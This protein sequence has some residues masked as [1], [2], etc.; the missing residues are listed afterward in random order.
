MVIGKKLKPALGLQEKHLMENTSLHKESS[1]S[2]DFIDDRDI[3]FPVTVPDICHLT[4][5]KILISIAKQTN[6][7]YLFISDFDESL[8]HNTI[9][10]VQQEIFCTMDKMKKNNKEKLE[11]KK[12]ESQWLRN[13]KMV[14][15]AWHTKRGLIHNHV[16][17]SLS[18]CGGYCS[19]CE[20]F[21]EKVI[22]CESCRRNL[23]SSCDLI[24][25][26]RMVFHTRVISDGISR[27]FLLPHQFLNDNREIMEK[28]KTT[29][30]PKLVYYVD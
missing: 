23:C 12:S 28:S 16:L 17:S 18:F 1:K 4:G 15:Q 14:E 26:R 21:E 9:A 8:L 24:T 10:D 27:S 29:N 2:G 22:R 13:V 11:V 30:F 20:K 5:N 7:V 3:I 25:H 19:D 6:V